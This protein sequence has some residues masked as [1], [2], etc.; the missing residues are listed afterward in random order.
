MNDSIKK[1]F[2]LLFR[3]VLICTAA[4]SVMMVVSFIKTAVFVTERDGHIA[5]ND[6]GVFVDG[7]Y[8]FT[9]LYI[10]VFYAL[11]ACVIL[12][13]VS[14]H[15]CTKFT[16]IGRTVIL[17]MTAYRMFRGLGIAKALNTMGKYAREIGVE[18]MNGMTTKELAS[19]LNV[20]QSEIEGLENMI[21][22]SD[23]NSEFTYMLAATF[24]CAVVLVIFFLTSIHNLTKKESPAACGGCDDANRLEQGDAAMLAGGAHFTQQGMGQSIPQGV[25]V[26]GNQQGSVAQQQMPQ[27]L[28]D[29]SRELGGNIEGSK[30]I[31]RYMAATQQQPV[32]D[33][34]DSAE[35]HD[36]EADGE[37]HD[38]AQ[39]EADMTDDSSDYL[40]QLQAEENHGTSLT[41]EDFM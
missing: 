37:F 3:T 38:Y 8:T 20:D 25:P 4:A 35:V 28:Q 12:S 18:K 33:H 27:I 1:A 15:K 16:L 10:G 11:I 19:A 22:S 7:C 23:T 36:M 32:H 9:Q 2:N 41:D 17:G 39:A 40:A 24:I 26:Q 21:K 5:D 13:I 34:H 29:L 31:S 6:M 14:F 30:L